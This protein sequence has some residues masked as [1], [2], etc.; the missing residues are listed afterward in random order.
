MSG[1]RALKAPWRAFRAASSWRVYDSDGNAVAKMPASEGPASQ[2]LAYAARL[3]AKT[4]ELEL[5]L[6]ECAAMLGVAADAID[7]VERA[8]GL[9]PNA[10]KLMHA[11]AREC[12]ELLHAIAVAQTEQKVQLP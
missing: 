2:R 4:P 3:I 5:M 1:A 8:P 10:S 11:K 7:Q 12:V 6:A 9:N